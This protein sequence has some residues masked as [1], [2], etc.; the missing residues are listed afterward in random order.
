M[1]EDKHPHLL[2][3]YALTSLEPEETRSIE[4]H[5]RWCRRCRDEVETLSA[6]RK[7]RYPREGEDLIPAVEPALRADPVLPGAGVRLRDS[8]RR[9]WPAA[10]ASLTLLAAVSVLAFAP[11]A[12][13]FRREPGP[14]AV[15][16][17]APS[18]GGAEPRVLAGPGPWEVRVLLPFDAPS[19]S[20]NVRVRMDGDSPAGPPLAARAT[21]DGQIEM[22]LANLL[23][24]RYEL[25][26]LPAGSP[27]PA[28]YVYSFL[29][30]R[31]PWDAAGS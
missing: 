18:R 20:Y 13:W 31:L 2:L 19:G 17:E 14:V 27:G 28:G 30:V 29:V 15:V 4:R 16:F 25:V 5:L 1:K 7:S 3:W 22:T 10:A 11:P 21:S 9:W 23:P 24:G 6:F 26:L 12:A 8:F